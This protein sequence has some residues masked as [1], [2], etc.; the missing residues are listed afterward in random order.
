MI[1]GNG[2]VRKK[3]A[4]RPYTKRG[5]VKES[6]AVKKESNEEYAMQEKDLVKAR[7][8]RANRRSSG[9][10][11]DGK[12]NEDG[13]NEKKNDIEQEEGNVMMTEG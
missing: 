12:E 13:S 7:A 8:A 6:D 4:K 1:N 10:F 9:R 5:A 3:R 2:E 11:V